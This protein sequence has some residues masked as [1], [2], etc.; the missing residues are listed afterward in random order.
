MGDPLPG[1][2]KS[3]SAPAVPGTWRFL[4][5]LAVGELVVTHGTIKVSDGMAIQI[6]ARQEGHESLQDLLRQGRDSGNMG[7][8]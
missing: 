7:T 5:G 8:R 3:E 1:K 2:P 6:R 4:E